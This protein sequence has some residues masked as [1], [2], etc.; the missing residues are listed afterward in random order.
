MG[1]VLSLLPQAMRHPHLE[2]ALVESGSVSCRPE[3][4][5]LYSPSDRREGA[6]IC[7]LGLRRDRVDQQNAVK[8]MT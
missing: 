2:T 7:R 6:I 5:L 4:L 8:S 3:W 1:G